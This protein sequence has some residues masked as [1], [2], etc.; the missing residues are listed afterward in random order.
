MPTLEL[1]VDHNLSSE[2]MGILVNTL[3]FLQLRNASYV[4]AGGDA[5]LERVFELKNHM[6]QG[7]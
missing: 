3:T 5:L 1:A 7:L 4:P 6:L 2:K